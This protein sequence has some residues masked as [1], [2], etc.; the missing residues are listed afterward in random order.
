MQKIEQ[1]MLA[2]E[3]L[4]LMFK[5]AI[6]W[7]IYDIVMIR[8]GFAGHV[9]LIFAPRGRPLVEP[10]MIK[11]H[12]IMYKNMI[13]PIKSGAFRYEVSFKNTPGAWKYHKRLVFDILL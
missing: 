10:Y 5:N 2:S 3:N 12:N 7:T 9:F 1:A 6:Y 4:H 13:C 8:L 11:K